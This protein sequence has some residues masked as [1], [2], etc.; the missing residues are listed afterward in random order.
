MT[1]TGSLHH[2]AGSTRGVAGVDKA[3]LSDPPASDRVSGGDR[4]NVPTPRR[5][6][7]LGYQG[8]RSGEP[9]EHRAL[10]QVGERRSEAAAFCRFQRCRVFEG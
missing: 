6:D 9:R 3:C 5:A 10:D 7:R 4:A 8:P 2:G 1:S